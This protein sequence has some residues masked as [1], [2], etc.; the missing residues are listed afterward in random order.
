MIVGFRNMLVRNTYAATHFAWPSIHTS[1]C[2]G[3][4]TAASSSRL[5]TISPLST[6]H[7]TRPLSLQSRSI[8]DPKWTKLSTTTKHTD[9]YRI[10]YQTRNSWFKLA[11]M[12]AL[13]GGVL[14]S[15]HAF[16]EQ[17][18]KADAAQVSVPSTV[19][20]KLSPAEKYAEYLELLKNYP[21][22]LGPLGNY[23]RGEI[24]IETDPE[25]MAEISALRKR[26]VGIAM[27]DKYWLVLNDAV[28]FPNGT[29]GVYG[30]LLW[31]NS[32]QGP[33]GVAVMPVLPNGKIPLSLTFRHAT[34]SWEYELP[35]GCLNEGE[36]PVDGAIRE[37]REETGM[38]LAEVEFLGMVAPDTG[39]TNTIVPVYIAKVV[40]KNAAT[41]EDSEAIADIVAFSVDEIRAGYKK[42]FLMGM[43][44]GKPT[45]I[46]LRDPF[47]SFALFQS[48]WRGADEE[49]PV[50]QR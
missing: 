17:Y 7:C 48:G 49:W 47:L 30:R 19:P 5:A 26:E 6:L 16:G 24:Q 29:V 31:M 36:Q 39:L 45:E 46:P 50:S 32:L 18:A 34:R 25:K 10:V 41:P 12:V 8:N 11:C 37:A 1:N 27:R 38:E 43:V 13:A 28:I 33:S 2:F 14:L 3:F 42:G 35:R 22:T 15:T 23:K 21:T 4:N 9:N 40:G 20:L 44:D